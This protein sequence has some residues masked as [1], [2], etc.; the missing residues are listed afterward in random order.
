MQS[1]NVGVEMTASFSGGDVRRDEVVEHPIRHA[2]GQVSEP[3]DVVILH[4]A[5]GC[6]EA[7]ASCWVGSQPSVSRFADARSQCREPQDDA[8]QHWRE[9]RAKDFCLARV[10]ADSEGS[11]DQG[12]REDVLKCK[13]LA[14]GDVRGIDCAAWYH[15]LAID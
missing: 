7:H 15:A 13:E 5:V 11:E 2:G 4:I 12:L 8:H 6:H 3:M 10:Q 14:S 1:R 9:R